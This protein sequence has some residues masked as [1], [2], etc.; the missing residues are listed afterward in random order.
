MK[1]WTGLIYRHYPTPNSH[2]DLQDL[3]D[4]RSSGFPTD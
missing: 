2:Q 3:A 1:G 4:A